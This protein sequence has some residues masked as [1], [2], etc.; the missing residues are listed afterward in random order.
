M[1]NSTAAA[2]SDKSPAPLSPVDCWAF[3]GEQQ[4]DFAGMLQ[5][6]GLAPVPLAPKSKRPLIAY[7]DVLDDDGFAIRPDEAAFYLYTVL[8][9]RWDPSGARRVPNVGQRL[10]PEIVCLDFD[11]PE[12]A[13]AWLEDRGF[14]RPTTLTIGTGR[15]GGGYH[16][17]YRL[18]PELRGK[19]RGATTWRQAAGRGWD[20]WP[21]GI[22]LLGTHQLAACP[23]SVHRTGT[24]YQPLYPVDLTPERYV[25]AFID[26][27]NGVDCGLI[28]EAPDWV[29]ELVEMVIDRRGHRKKNARGNGSSRGMPAPM[30]VR[31]A[32]VSL[33]VKLGYVCDVDDGEL[34]RPRCPHPAHDDDDPSA[35]INTIKATWI[36][37]SCGR[38]GGCVDLYRAHDVPLPK[39][40]VDYCRARGED[41]T[42]FARF[43]R[44]PLPDVEVVPLDEARH[45]VA[46]T[47]LAIRASA[48]RHG[49]ARRYAIQARKA[50]RE[51]GEA[52]STPMPDPARVTLDRS[53]PGTGKTHA[54]LEA[55]A[56]HSKEGGSGV[57]VAERHKQIEQ[58]VEEAEDFGGRELIE[59]YPGC[60]HYEIA[61]TPDARLCEEKR[62][63]KRMEKAR[64]RGFSAKR[65]VCDVLCPRRGQCEFHD[66][67]ERLSTR[68]PGCETVL[69]H[70]QLPLPWPYRRSAAMLTTWCS[71]RTRCST[72]RVS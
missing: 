37:H 25:E 62:F 59:W 46:D 19:V 28:I 67:K 40:L 72:S 20:W 52:P 6:A 56:V 50:A 10:P 49:R 48:E 47:H 27:R 15:V 38:S 51:T 17:Y 5:A 11:E 65:T 22:D 34:R 54:A 68:R 36:C 26:A 60:G 2:P 58:V 63:V 71:T 3:S 23:G 9:H 16:E 35:S 33:L 30:V 24:R 41:S 29:C 13:E 66:A 53:G 64:E 12:L 18:P 69:T 44:A 45:R 4:V 14:V 8:M 55:A 32:F 21:D 31:E 42:R 1:P 7:S 43:E 39:S 70:A 61:K 57:F